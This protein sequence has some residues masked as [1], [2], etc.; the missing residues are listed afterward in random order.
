[1]TVCCGPQGAPQYGAEGIRTPDPHNAIVVL[2]QL[3]YDPF[4]TLL[5]YVIKPAATRK[6]QS[7]I[8]DCVVREFVRAYVGKSLRLRLRCGLL[9]SMR[10]AT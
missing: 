9:H 6:I 10:A 1:M 4:C 7:G 3:S 5:L 8:T 2:Y